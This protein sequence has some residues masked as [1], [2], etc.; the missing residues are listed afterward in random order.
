[1][2]CGVI[3]TVVLTFISIKMRKSN[4]DGE[5][6]FGIVILIVALLCLFLASIPTYF[7]WGYFF[8]DEKASQLPAL[9]SIF[10]MFGAASI[11]C[12]GEYFGAYGKY[13]NQTIE[14]VT[15]W[16]GKK[17][18]QWSDLDSIEFVSWANWY[19][20]TF[21]SGDK[22]RLSNLLYGHADVVKMA[23]I[24]KHGSEVK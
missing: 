9:T 7:F 24:F 18:E 16:T 10:L 2:V 19:L 11:Y 23:D 4:T 15:P 17:K 1:M 5:L 8:G 22:I 21:K 20:L 13:D 6:R 12:F 14:F 3:T